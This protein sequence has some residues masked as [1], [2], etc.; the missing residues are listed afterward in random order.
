MS[1]FYYW[2]CNAKKSKIWKIVHAAIRDAFEKECAV[3]VFR[4]TGKKGKFQP[5]FSQ[6]RRK[7]II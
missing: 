5:V 6:L 2:V 7:R 1:K 3:N 4:I